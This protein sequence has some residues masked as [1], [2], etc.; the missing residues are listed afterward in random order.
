M[1]KPES[2]HQEQGFTLV[3]VLVAILLTTLFVATAMQA[4]V[5]AAVFKSRTRQFAEA[6]IWIQEDLEN[7]KNEAAKFQSTSLT[8]PATPGLSYI[9]VASVVDFAVHDT[10]KVGSDPGTY[11]INA[12]SG[13]VLTIRPVLPLGFNQ[14]LGAPVVETTIFQSTSLKVNTA[15]NTSVL[16]V[17]LVD[18]FRIGDTL[19]VGTDETNNVILS[20]APS[21]TSPTLTLT[22]NLGTSQV[23]NAVVVVINN[24]C[25]PPVGSSTKGFAK[26][27]WDK[28][29]AVPSVTSNTSNPNIG[30]RPI[31]N[32]DYTLTR[33][34]NYKLDT[35]GNAVHPYEVLTLTYT[36][37][38]QSG[39]SAIEKMNIE[40]VPDAVFQCSLQ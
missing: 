4:V 32:K 19:K 11:T 7:V 5:I 29:P 22:Q 8:A 21:V 23:A 15:A 14:P 20:I 39:G 17:P 28:L 13:T 36:A 37:V 18:G 9:N 3:E 38:P 35:S 27:I 12:I 10:L 6:T 26:S 33:T 2:P 25:N 31:S 1:F 24:Q 34:P 40:V 30:T 16:Q